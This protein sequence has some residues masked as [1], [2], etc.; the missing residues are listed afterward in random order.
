MARAKPGRRSH[1]GEMTQEAHRVPM[2][3]DARNVPGNPGTDFAF[4]NE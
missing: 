2:G 1:D 4:S 3:M